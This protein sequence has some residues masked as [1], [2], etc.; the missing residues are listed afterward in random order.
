[1]A[2]QTLERTP[3]PFFRQGPSAF[4]RLAFYAAL[5]L[6]LMAMDARWHLVS[7]LRRV[8]ATVIEPAVQIARA[9]GLALGAMAGYFESLREA[10]QD[11]DAQRKA[12]VQLALKAELASQLQSENAS[13]R[14][15]LKLKQSV[16]IHS[17]AAEI[18]AQASDPFSRKLF[19]DRGSLAGVTLGSP[20]IDE[21]GLL[22]QVTQVDPISSQVTLVTDR[23][24]A[25]PVEVAR[26]GQRGIL[27]GDADAT[28]G[29]ME[30]RWQA[31][32]TDVRVG[33][34]LVTSGLD[35]IYP[36]GL[37][38]ARVTEVQRRPDA[39]F[40]RVLCAPLAHVNG[41]RHVLVLKPLAPLA[42]A[43]A[44]A[45]AKRGAPAHP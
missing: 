30:L 9:P 8:I 27:A 28:A 10:Q 11:A 35:G 18:V 31:S 32:D 2:F 41:G 4:T 26:D 16:P 13:L 43:P 23:D 17:I 24:S 21:T 15:L 45:A 36:A 22:G 38:V 29:G 7:P 5:S 33:D 6:L 39:A 25:V 12:N 14:A 20:V 40:A 42:M 3:P 44:P 37:A 34:I 1:M 19:I